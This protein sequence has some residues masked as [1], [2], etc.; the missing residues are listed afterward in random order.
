[1]SGVTT[2]LQRASEPPTVIARTRGTLRK[3]GLDTAETSAS[4]RTLASGSAA[5]NERFRCTAESGCADSN[6]A[7]NRRGGTLLPD[8]RP[9]ACVPT[10]WPTKRGAWTAPSCR[11]CTV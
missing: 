9:V 4:R 8:V 10:V 5:R 11:S 1:M 7:G 2:I 6:G 3:T